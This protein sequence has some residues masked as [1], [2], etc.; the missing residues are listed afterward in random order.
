[1]PGSRR[2]TD[3]GAG[4]EQQSAT[5]LV[6]E[7]SGDLTSMVTRG[8]SFTAGAELLEEMKDMQVLRITANGR[9]FRQV[10]LGRHFNQQ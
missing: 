3:G 1:M 10:W 6:G 4:V 5:T 2:S 7:K 9:L 8:A